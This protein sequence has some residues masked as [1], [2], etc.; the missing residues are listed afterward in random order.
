MDCDL[1]RR[2][3]ISRADGLRQFQHAREHGRHELGVGDAVFLDEL[4][5]ALLVETLHH[6]DVPPRLSVPPTPANGAE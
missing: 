5:E 3:I 2:E 1:E 6:D 4:K